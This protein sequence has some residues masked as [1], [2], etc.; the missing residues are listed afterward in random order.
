MNINDPHL[1]AAKPTTLRRRL[2]WGAA[3]VVVAGAIAWVVLHP[4]PHTGGPAQPGGGR[5]GRAAF[6]TG[7]MPVVA[8]TASKANLDVT[9]NAL[10]TVSPLA[11]VTVKTQIAGQLVELGFQEG[12]MV[13]KGDFLAQIDPRPYQQQLDQSQGQLARDQAL[14]KQAE[15]DLK[16]YKTLLS[17]DSIAS[18]TVDQQE[19]LVEQYK[20]TVITDQAN[21]GTAKLNL[22]YCHITAPV[23]G[24]VGLRQVD[25][26]NYVQTSDANGLV[27]IT[28]MQPMSVV[29]TLPEDQLPQVLQQTTKGKQ[30]KVAAYD[31]AKTVKLAEGKLDTIDN[32]ID[33]STGTVKLRALFANDPE[34][35]YP[36]QFVNVDLLVNTLTDA[37]TV[38]T[39]AVQNGA[40]GSYVYLVKGD[41]T[42]TVRPVKIGP[43]SGDKVAILDGLQ[44][45][46]KVV[47]DGADKLREG[48][49]VTL[50]AEGE[51]QAPAAHGANP[52]SSVEGQ[53][54]ER[55]RRDKDASQPQ[56]QKPQ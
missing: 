11:T 55:G 56:K 34:V 6:Q 24:R 27:V 10:G 1:I 2:I 12:Q 54:Q 51:G 38:P 20:G 18:Q 22:I 44:A 33:V 15:I 9:L 3:L 50:P 19:S 36:Q 53:P 26:G 41:D 40:P 21:V 25:L 5:G 39:A 13:K 8:A 23:T 45:G 17:E 32:Q 43:Q 47:V 29:F 28:Q 48:S 4:K 31:R 14:L 16:R 52:P 30:L 35:L 46:D 42:V 49:Q 7:P 37:T